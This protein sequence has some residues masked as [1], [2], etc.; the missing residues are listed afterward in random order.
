ME[1]LTT[2]S[3]QLFSYAYVFSGAEE[4]EEVHLNMIYFKSVSFF[5]ALVQSEGNILE[6]L[7][8][9]LSSQVYY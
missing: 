8:R 2:V 7:N 6:R 1:A 3:K 9:K 5:G 4:I